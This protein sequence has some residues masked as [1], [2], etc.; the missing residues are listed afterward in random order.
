MRDDCQYFDRLGVLC[1][2]LRK[3]LQRDVLLPGLESKISQG[4]AVVEIEN[5][6]ELLIRSD[7]ALK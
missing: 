7:S 4:K 6:G 1:T 5:V 2:F 3:F